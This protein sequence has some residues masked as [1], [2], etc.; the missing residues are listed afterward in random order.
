M[1]QK[2]VIGILTLG[3]TPRPNL[4]TEVQTIVPNAER[5]IRGGLDG[6]SRKEIEMFR[7]DAAYSL[8][9]RLACGDTIDVDIYDLLPN[10]GKQTELLAQAG[11]G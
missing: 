1:T 11:A 6:L 4:V 8:M 2:P 7:A 5:P 9:V 3:Q 10:L